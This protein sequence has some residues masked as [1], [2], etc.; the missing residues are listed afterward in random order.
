MIP[1]DSEYQTHWIWNQFYSSP[2]PIQTLLSCKSPLNCL[3]SIFQWDISLATIIQLVYL[4]IGMCISWLPTIPQV[5]P[6]LFPSGSILVV[7]H[8]VSI[9]LPSGNDSHW[10]YH[11]ISFHHLSWLECISTQYPWMTLVESLPILVW[12]RI[13]SSPILPSRMYPPQMVLLDQPMVLNLSDDLMV[14]WITIPIQCLLHSE[15]LLQSSLI[16]L[17]VLMADIQSSNHNSSISS[18]I[19][20]LQRI[21]TIQSSGISIH[22]HSDLSPIPSLFGLFGNSPREWPH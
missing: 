20:M 6:M 14:I 17:M 1:V 19:V 2:N 15:W 8:W 4:V 21:L 3:H 18:V 9:V 7:Y 12:F 5:V 11:S 13:Y 10:K 22:H 16:L